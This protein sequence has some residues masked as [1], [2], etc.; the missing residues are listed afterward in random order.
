V[1]TLFDAQQFSNFHF[2]LAECTWTREPDLPLHFKGS[3]DQDGGIELSEPVQ[4]WFSDQTTPNLPPSQLSNSQQSNSVHFKLEPCQND[5]HGGICATFS[6]QPS[7]FMPKSSQM[8]GL[9]VREAQKYFVELYSAFASF[10]THWTAVRIKRT[11][12]NVVSVDHACTTENVYK[13]MEKGPI[14][15]TENCTFDSIF[16]VHDLEY[17]WHPANK[18]QWMTPSAIAARQ[19]VVMYYDGGCPICEA[20]VGYYKKLDAEVNFSR[21]MN[22]V[23]ISVQKHKKW[24]NNDLARDFGISHAQALAQMHV[25][26]ESGV[27]HTGIAAFLPVWRRLPYWSLL[28]QIITHVPFVLSTAEICYSEFWLRFRTK[29]AAPND[30]QSS[31]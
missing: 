17:Y 27:L 4:G 30:Q 15:N 18:S 13:F 3:L 5:D 22:F 11:R 8:A 23:D 28:A 10:D 7:L 25:V 20:E 26:D 19:P 12:W 1:L 2:N 9:H 6:M 21:P 24:Q 31:R 16:Y 14:F 29:P